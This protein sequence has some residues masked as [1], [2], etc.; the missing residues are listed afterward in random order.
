MN[1]V[2]G[3]DKPVCLLL[4]VRCPDC[5]GKVRRRTISTKDIF[6]QETYCRECKRPFTE[7][8]VQNLII[9]TQRDFL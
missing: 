1:Q 2:F 7:G 5:L 3:N 4:D 8:Q 9:R 6:I